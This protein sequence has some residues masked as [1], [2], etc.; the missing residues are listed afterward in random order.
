[1]VFSLTVFSVFASTVEAQNIEDFFVDVSFR[2]YNNY[3]GSFSWSPADYFTLGSWSGMYQDTVSASFIPYY[4]FQNKIVEDDQ[5]VMIVMLEGYA[6]I[7]TLKKGSILEVEMSIS[8]NS[9]ITHYQP[10]QAIFGILEEHHADYPTIYGGAQV[11]GEYVSTSGYENYYGPGIDYAWK[12]DSVTISFSYQAEEDIN[13]DSHILQFA[14]QF[15]DSWSYQFTNDFYCSFDYLKFKYQD[16]ETEVISTITQNTNKIINSIDKANQ[17]LINSMSPDHLPTDKNESS[18]ND[19]QN[20]ESEVMDSANQ[21][22]DSFSSIIDSFSID[23][24][25]NTFRSMNFLSGTINSI[26]DGLSLG[27]LINYLII[28]GSFGMLLSIGISIGVK[29]YNKSHPKPRQTYNRK[30]GG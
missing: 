28:L 14:R 22:V 15:D 10:T 21:G 5:K 29:Q 4:E 8:F 1:M 23:S 13:Y 17:D 25:N 16:D 18:F 26:V 6:P 24:R 27:T 19:L 3:D 7:S 2:T 20:A 30:R 12:A 9:P 11:S